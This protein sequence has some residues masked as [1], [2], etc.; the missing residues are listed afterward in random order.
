[1]K[2]KTIIYMSNNFKEDLKKVK[3]FAFDVDGVFSTV[4]TY[5]H[6]SGELMRT[7]N[8]HDGYAMQY[9][10]KLGYPVGIISRG[11]SDSVYKR[12]ERLGI[13]DIYLQCTDKLKAL[14]KFLTKHH[15]D[16][17]EV[18]YMGDDLPDLEVL[19]HVGIPTCPANAVYEVKNICQYISDKKGGHG[20]VRD[21]LEQALKLHGNWM[22][23]E[24]I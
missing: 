22:N 19:S 10:L 1:M 2:G 7:M 3:A 5:L 18:L 16:P 9:T 15:L 6:P 4:E 14:N 12:F 13:N 21:V 23:K 17:G 8:L 11:D 24:L 20:C